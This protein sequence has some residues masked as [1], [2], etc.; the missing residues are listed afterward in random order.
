MKEIRITIEGLVS[1]IDSNSI[2]DT[3]KNKATDV[4]EY[5]LETTMPA[6]LKKVQNHEIPP[7]EMSQ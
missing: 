7:N 3:L 1:V 2:S 6:G 5:I 4:L